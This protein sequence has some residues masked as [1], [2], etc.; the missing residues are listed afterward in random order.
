M[1]C[2]H[3]LC[4]VALALLAGCGARG[5]SSPFVP[6]PFD[7][8]KEV[9]E[10]RLQEILADPT[11]QYTTIGEYHIGPG[12]E[13]AISLLGRPDILGERLEDGQR[14]RVTVTDSPTVTLPY[15]GAIRVHGKTATQL[16]D[17]LAIAFADFVRNP[18]PLVTV[19]KSFQNRIAVLGTVRSPGRFNLETGDT[20]LE[21]IF[22]AGGLTFG[23]RTGGLAPGRYLKVYRHKIP[24]ADRVTYTLEEL[25]EKLDGDVEQLGRQEII[26]PIEDFINAGE[27]AWNIQMMPGDIVYIPPAGT[28][29]VHGRVEEPGVVFLGPSLR[30]V[31]QAIAERGGN[32][33]GAESV[34]EVV[35]Q[36]PGEDPESFYLNMRRMQLR[37]EQDFLL[38]DGDEIFVYTHFGRAV[39]EFINAIF[40]TS[41]RAGASATYNPQ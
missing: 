4:L 32:R 1:N 34:V 3:L 26:I 29:F 15:I 33:I 16:E 23:G 41:I 37:K 24:T 28:V 35:R 30:T 38:R 5:P 27:L 17:E 8:E 7:P 11:S 12:D 10:A 31:T 22:R 40:Q 39:L 9:V 18:V 20:L 19:E 6:P 13:V 25:L 14:F 2:K 36:A 21:V